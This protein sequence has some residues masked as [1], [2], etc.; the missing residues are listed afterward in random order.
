RTLRQRN[1][2]R[3]CRSGRDYP[4]RSWC[5]RPGTKQSRARIR[6]V[7]I[8][9]QFAWDY[10]QRALWHFWRLNASDIQ[11]A[12][13]LF[14]QSIKLD[15]NFSPALAFLSYAHITNYTRGYVE[16]RS[17]ELSAAQDAAKRA[18]TIGND[19]GLSHWALGVVAIFKRDHDLAL[20]EL[21]IAMDL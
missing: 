10:Y 17:S 6:K 5:D 19:D 13:R 20:S 11:E 8:P 14:N 9:E 18:I 15:P 4:N 1:F 3:F 7:E 21:A 16:P 2:R 12:I